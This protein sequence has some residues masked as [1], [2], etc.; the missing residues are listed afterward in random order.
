MNESSRN[1]IRRLL[2]IIESPFGVKVWALNRRYCPGQAMTKDKVMVMYSGKWV[3]YASPF[4]YETIGN[5]TPNCNKDSFKRAYY[6]ERE[7]KFNLDAKDG[8]RINA[9]WKFYKE[10]KKGHVILFVYGCDLL[11]YY[12]V[13]D[14]NVECEM[15]ENYCIHAKKAESIM[16]DAPI[17]LKIAFAHPFFKEAGTHI[18]E[19]K[20]VLKRLC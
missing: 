13:N 15:G 16:F 5:M 19:I 17:D 8:S 2:D 6:I 18:E 20:N 1:G 11:G 7:T 14:D 9:L 3:D 4:A 10:V 12:I